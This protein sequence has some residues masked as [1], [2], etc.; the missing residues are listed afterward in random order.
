MYVFIDIFPLLAIPVLI[1][2]FLVLTS[3][4]GPSD[5]VASWLAAPVFTIHAF[6]GDA[7]AVSGGDIL[8]IVAV[9]LLFVEIVK[10][11]RTDSMSLLNHGLAALVFVVFLV[12]FL[13][14]RGFTTSVFF[15]ML[16]MQLVDVVAGYTV[17]AVAAKRDFGSPGGI[18]G[19]N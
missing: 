11:T 9:L 17:T 18:I 4:S 12:E 3:I 14:L 7:W 13:T 6:S 1:Y 19:T 15:V 10:S 2:N 5:Q 16:L 8:V